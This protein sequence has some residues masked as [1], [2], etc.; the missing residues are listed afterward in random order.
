MRLPTPIVIVLT[1]IL[2]LNSCSGGGAVIVD[3]NKKHIS[4]GTKIEKLVILGPEFVYHRDEN[5]S[6]FIIARERQK[7]RYIGL[8]QKAAKQNDL[9][10]E[11]I[12][13]EDISND[14]N[15]WFN[16]LTSLRRHLFSMNF[17][18]DPYFDKEYLSG[19]TRAP[20][21]Y[22]TRLPI[23]DPKYAS[24]SKELG[25]PSISPSILSIRCTNS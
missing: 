21:R 7:R 13:P 23:I 22:A 17:Y 1:F 2:I 18:Q 6:T 4:Q 8:M 25:T 24:L 10:L 11:V 3:W 15:T 12:I 14:D 20:S 16:S 5:N 19:Y 9:E